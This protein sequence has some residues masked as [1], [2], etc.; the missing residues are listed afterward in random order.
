MRILDLEV[1]G[2]RSLK[3]QRWCPAGLNLVIGPNGSGKSNLLSVL[4]MLVHAANGGLGGYVQ[5]K[6]GMEPLL[7]DGRADRIRVRTKMWP[8]E[9]ESMNSLA[10]EL[11]LE[12][13]GNSSAYHI[14]N[15]SLGNFSKVER[16]L[17]KEPFKLLERDTRRAVVFS[18]ESQQFEAPP[19]SLPEGEPL[20]SVAGG[21]FA[22]NSVVGQFRDELAAWGIYQGF[23]THPEAAVRQATVSR[24]ETRV[25][26]D[27]Q[28]LI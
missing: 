5:R 3:H 27:G 16:G 6:G 28:N 22:A 15:E 1:E 14:S 20:L 2:Y 25:Q 21:P 8:I 13:L 12:R 18:A 24:N 23:H 11:T 10:Y 17:A 9:H 4:E 19:D 26:P 7:W